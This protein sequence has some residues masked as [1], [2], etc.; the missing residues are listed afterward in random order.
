VPLHWML[1]AGGLTAVITL[2][3]A[4]L[5]TRGAPEEVGT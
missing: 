3:L 4:P 2:M 1:L 5:L